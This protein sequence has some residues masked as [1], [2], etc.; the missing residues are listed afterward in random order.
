LLRH[1]HARQIVE[2][3]LL[4]TGFLCWFRKRHKAEVSLHFLF[5]IPYDTKNHEKTTILVARHP[6]VSDFPAEFSA[7]IY[8]ENFLDNM[9]FGC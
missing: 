4:F 1:K 5:A 9:F 8:G 2:R 7:F 6:F 3:I